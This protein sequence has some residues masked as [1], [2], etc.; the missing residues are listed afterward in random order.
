[1][2]TPGTIASNWTWR[3]GQADLDASVQQ[4]LLDLTRRTG[5]LAGRPGS[6]GT[7]NDAGRT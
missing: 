7:L 2:N 1:M 3:L 5:R 4:R 6:A